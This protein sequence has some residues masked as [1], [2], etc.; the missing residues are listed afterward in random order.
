MSYIALQNFSTTVFLL[1]PY[2][3]SRKYK[4]KKLRDLIY[5]TFVLLSAGIHIL[6]TCPVHF[7]FIWAYGCVLFDVAMKLL[8]I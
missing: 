7:L 3:L 4:A 1:I 2:T 6:A 5:V 8:A